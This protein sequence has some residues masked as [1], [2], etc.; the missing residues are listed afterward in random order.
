M[1]RFGLT[2]DLQK[3]PDKISTYVRHHQQVWPE[4]IDS[5]KSSGIV[6]MEIYQVSTRLFMWIEAEDDFSFEE[7]AKLDQSNPNVQKWEDLMDLYQQR[8]PFAKSDEKW[9]LMTKIFQL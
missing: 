8:L 3:D 6:N 5:I 7:K 1:K 9:V 2:L 4:I